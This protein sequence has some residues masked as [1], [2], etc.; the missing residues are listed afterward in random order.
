MKEDVDHA[1]HRAG[2]LEGLSAR[3]LLFHAGS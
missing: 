1:E 3:W 2:A